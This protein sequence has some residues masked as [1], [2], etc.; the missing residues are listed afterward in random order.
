MVKHKKKGPRS[1][2]RYMLKK[3]VRERGFPKPNEFLK[4]FETGEIVHIKT[5]PS[6]HGGMPFR[7]FHGKTGRIVGKQGEC[8]YI[9]I[10][11]GNS[12]KK[13]LVHPVHLKK[14]M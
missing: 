7:R 2:T 8:Y 4:E 14:A 6:Y 3:K 1:K 13:V 12:I 9:E 11:D 5:N 10:R